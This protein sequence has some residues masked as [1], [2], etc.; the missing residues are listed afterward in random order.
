[1]HHIEQ[2]YRTG[3]GSDRACA[4]LAS[5]VSAKSVGLKSDPLDFRLCGNDKP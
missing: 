4:G 5:R 2:P 1:M 3:R